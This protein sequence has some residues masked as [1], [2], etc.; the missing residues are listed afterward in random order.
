MKELLKLAEEKCF[1]PRTFSS[2]WTI[3]VLLERKKNF[4]VNEYCISNTLNEI[5]KWLRE[6]YKIHIDIVHWE[7]EKWYFYIKDG[8]TSPV[9]TIKIE[10]KEND[11]WEFKYYEQALEAGLY[12]ALKLI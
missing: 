10:I 7:L 9:K 2:S 11:K 5:Q 6:T 4:A 12:E 8:R 3:D 1:K